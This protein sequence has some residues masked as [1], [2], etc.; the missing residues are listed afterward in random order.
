MNL[1][2]SLFRPHL[3]HV[4]SQEGLAKPQERNHLDT[5]Q[6][7]LVMLPH[8]DSAFNFARFLTRDSIAAEDVVQEAFMR[9]FRSFST[10]Q[11]GSA[12]G[13]LFAIIRNCFYDRIKAQGN[14]QTVSYSDEVPE[15]FDDQTPESLLLQKCDI[16]LVRTALESVPEPFRE[17]LVLRE[18]EEMSYKEIAVLTCV[19]IGTVMSRLARARH[20]L[21]VLLI[22]NLATI[23]KAKT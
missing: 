18:L 21:E 7:R 20:M 14:L 6:F 12:K 9:A 17:A 3:V 22:D 2:K 8:L 13:W 23:G 10:Y 19:P 16:A 5:E 15:A 1:G 4:P 11:R